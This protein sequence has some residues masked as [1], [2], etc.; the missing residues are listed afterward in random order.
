VGQLTAS[1][2]HEINQPLMSIVSNAGASLRWLDRPTPELV[3]ARAGLRDIITEGKR[4]AGI[5]QGL[6]NLTR[7]AAPAFTRVNLHA[8][9]R[10]ILMLS[11]SELERREVAL[12]LAL[13]PV[14]VY[15]LGDL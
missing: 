6:Q 12:N 3:H 14:D 1:I 7:N 10:H 11:R 2:A 15:V 9:I 8:L 13:N 5:I 4:A